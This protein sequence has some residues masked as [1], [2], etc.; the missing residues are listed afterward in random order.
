EDRGTSPRAPRPV[1]VERC[2]MPFTLCKRTPRAPRR[3]LGV[4]HLESRITPTL[5]TTPLLEAPGAG[6]ASALVTTSRAGGATA[7]A[8]WLH[9]GASGTGDGLA[10]FTFDANTGD[11]RTGT[12][13]IAGQTLTVTQAGSN[14][15]A[16]T[17]VTTVLSTPGLAGPNGVAVDGAGDV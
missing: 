14:Y 15:S 11:T 3:H 13:T 7:N 9:T 6:S 2:P 12:L 8:T 1:L 17:A 10:S 4:E 5:G 16:V